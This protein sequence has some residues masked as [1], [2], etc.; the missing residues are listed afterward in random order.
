MIIAITILATLTVSPVIEDPV[1]PDWV[2]FSLEPVNDGYQKILDEV[3]PHYGQIYRPPK[4]A[5][6]V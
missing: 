2:D 1:L 5:C 3:R 4:S 6:R